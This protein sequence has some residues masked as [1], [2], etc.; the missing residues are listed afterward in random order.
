[1]D[2]L[3]TSRIGI[4]GSKI[5]TS[6]DM[7]QS[8]CFASEKR[9]TAWCMSDGIFDE[10]LGGFP[11]PGELE[12]ASEQA[13]KK[14]YILKWSFQSG[15]FKSTCYFY[16]DRGAGSSVTEIYLETHGNDKEEWTKVPASIKDN[17]HFVDSNLAGG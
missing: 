11:V 16:R 15:V 8:K 4:S 13:R 12:W 3:S 5:A 17:L 10:E 14:E 7:L 6:C 1:M 9:F 2:L